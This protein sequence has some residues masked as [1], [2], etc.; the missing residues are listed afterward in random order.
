MVQIITSWCHPLLSEDHNLDYG[1]LMKF[2]LSIYKKNVALCLC[3]YSYC[4]VNLP[5][6]ATGKSSHKEA[7]FYSLCWSWKCFQHEK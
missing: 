4:F 1:G 5:Y 6:Q 7:L 2:A 3:G